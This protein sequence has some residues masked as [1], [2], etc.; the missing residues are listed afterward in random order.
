[1][2]DKTLV[3]EKPKSVF[4]NFAFICFQILFSIQRVISVKTSLL[5]GCS[6]R[7]SWCAAPG[8]SLIV[9]S[10]APHWLYSSSDPAGLQSQSA[11]PCRANTGVL[12]LQ[13][14]NICRDWESAI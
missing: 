4:E 12:Q 2:K 1:M 10:S 11:S 3:T 14:Y 6:S 8:N 7:K 13:N 5:V 9:L